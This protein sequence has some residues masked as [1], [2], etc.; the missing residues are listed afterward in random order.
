MRPHGTQATLEAR[1]RWAVALLGK[2]QTV[3]WVARTVGCSHSSVIRWRDAVAAHGPAILS[4]KPAPGG[5]AKL[6]VRQRQRIPA[7]LR[8]GA[9]KWGFGTDLWTMARIAEV[10]RREFGVRYHPTHVRRVLVQ[11]GWVLPRSR[12]RRPPVRSNRTT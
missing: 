10:I 3:T 6:T 8:R 12:R 1:R 5:P 2:G 9:L 11:L 4:A 7:L